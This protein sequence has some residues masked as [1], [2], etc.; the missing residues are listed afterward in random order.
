M[1]LF[2]W[3]FS[4]FLKISDIWPYR[5]ESFLSVS[6]RIVCYFFY[7]L[8]RTRSSSPSSPFHPLPLPAAIWDFLSSTSLSL[9]RV[10]F[11][12][13]SLSFWNR[14][15]PTR[16]ALAVFLF[17]FA[18]LALAAS[19]T[20]LLC[21]RPLQLRRSVIPGSFDFGVPFYYTFFS[22]SAFSFFI[23]FCPSLCLLP[24]ISRGLVG[25]VSC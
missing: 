9:Y 25:L 15:C 16:R 5:L 3:I 14:G 17:E 20:F 22:T 7:V 21:P 1:D 6:V 19:S 4:H 18:I 8:R 13:V 10:L 11:P 12:W 23:L 2:Y 24:A